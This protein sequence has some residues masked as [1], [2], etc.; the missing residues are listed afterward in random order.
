MFAA[1]Y[2]VVVGIEEYNKRISLQAWEDLW[3]QIHIFS[4]HKYETKNLLFYI[5]QKQTAD[6]IFSISYLVEYLTNINLH[7]SAT[8]GADGQWS[9]PIPSCLAPCLI[10]EIDFGFIEGSPVG[11]KLD[12]GV[13]VSVN[14]TNDYEVSSYEDI[15]CNNGS[16]NSVPKCVPAR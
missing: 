6:L 1:S 3:D 10:P 5:R 13:S 7:I 4:F 14:C 12:H 9:I 2:W 15:K 8:C 11:S 16:W